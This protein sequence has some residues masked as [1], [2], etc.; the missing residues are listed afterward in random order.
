MKTFIVIMFTFSLSLLFVAD[1]L[2]HLDMTNETVSKD[3][4]RIVGSMHNWDPS[5]SEMTVE[6]FS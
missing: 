3:G 4:V 1:V 2:F 5:T 6:Y